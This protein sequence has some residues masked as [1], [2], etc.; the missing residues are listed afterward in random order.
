MKKLRIWASITLTLAIL[1]FILL[2]LMIL[3]LL[4]IAHGEQNVVTEWGIVRLGL[5]V[6]FF[7]IVAS[8]VCTGLVLKYFRDKDPGAGSKPL[9]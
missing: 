9:D 2:V 8:S 5:L 3:A 7:L 4:D 1:A 6:L